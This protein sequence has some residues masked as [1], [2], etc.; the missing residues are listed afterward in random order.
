MADDV[1][2][3]ENII[4]KDLSKSIDNKPTKNI[5]NVFK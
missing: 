1:T 2:N 4:E 3:N 5:Y